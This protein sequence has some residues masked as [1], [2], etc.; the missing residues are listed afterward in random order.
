MPLQR[1]TLVHI[2]LSC[3]LAASAFQS[4]A[5]KHR[6]MASDHTLSRR[7]DC[8]SADP[9]DTVT[10]RLQQALTSNGVG[11]VLSLCPD[12][13]YF[14]TAPINYTHADQEISTV[15]YPTDGSR[16]TLVVSGPITNNTGH[17]TA[18]DGTCKGCNGLMLRNIQINGTREIG[19]QLKNS[20]ANIEMGGSNANQTIQFV[21]SYYAR[22]WSCLHIQEGALNCTGVIVQNNDI[23][24]CGVDTFPDWADGIS[25]S[26]RNG[27]VRNNLINT[28]TDGGIVLFGSPGTLVENNT[29]WVE[30][31]TLL[32]GI[33]MVDYEPWLGNYNGVIVRDNLITGGFADTAP[34]G[35][36]SDG[37]NA[38]NV[39][40]KIGIGIGPRTWFA[41]HF[42]SN[43]SQGGTVINNKFTGAF[44]FAIAMSSAKNFTIT[45]NTLTGNT[46]FI[47]QSSVNCSKGEAIPDNEPFV[48]DQN[49]TQD[50]TTQSDFFNISNGD[51]LPCLVA[52]NGTWWPFGGIPNDTSMTP[53]AGV[54]EPGS[55]PGAGSPGSPGS[56]SAGGGHSDD[57]GRK[58]GI[59]VG[60]IVGVL[61][62]AVGAWYLRKWALARQ[63]QN[64]ARPRTNSTGYVR[65]RDSVNRF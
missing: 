4:P 5:H 38:E 65:S 39:L 21:R 59:A 64:P 53:P 8:I 32:G 11:Y 35:S 47:G 54:A 1:F 62:A 45:G 42:G 18:I 3:V 46:S 56:S 10:T 48:V 26:C 60:I 55:T 20:G 27:I 7:D 44:G 12:E 30:N 29:I 58:A 34:S 19:P 52:P 13:T 51:N 61:A 6:R 9:Q 25:F 50:S 41:N 37:S 43:V 40:I 31:R 28:P 49:N 63:A 24:P 57:A 14:T 2:L 16:A 36:Q 17:T 22:G 33:N 23:G 15:G